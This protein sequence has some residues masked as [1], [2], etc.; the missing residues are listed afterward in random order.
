MIFER[1]NLNT[2]VC[3]IRIPQGTN[4]EIG[5]GIFIS[6]GNEC[7]LLTASHVIRSMIA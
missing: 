2:V 6:K 1:D 3:N 7:F 4:E 5:T